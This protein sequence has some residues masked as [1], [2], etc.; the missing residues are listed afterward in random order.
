[1]PVGCH[2]MVSPG[3]LSVFEFLD[4]LCVFSMEG[5]ELFA[6]IQQRAHNAFT[7]RGKLLHANPLFWSSTVLSCF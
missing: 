5:G 7:E 3:F 6:R 4:V 2:G 1:M